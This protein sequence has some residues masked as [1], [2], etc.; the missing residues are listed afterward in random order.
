M[1]GSPVRKLRWSMGGGFPIFLCL[2]AVTGLRACQPQRSRVTIENR[3]TQDVLVV[4]DTLYGERRYLVGACGRVELDPRD[5]GALDPSSPP[6]PGA[7][8]EPVVVP[9]L[10]D[11]AVFVTVV[12]TPERI[13]SS[14]GPSGSLPACQGLPPSPSP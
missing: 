10:S 8:V 1:V 2:V 11:S 6:P 13:V 5:A 14:L 3:T 4:G 7:V 12:I 9:F